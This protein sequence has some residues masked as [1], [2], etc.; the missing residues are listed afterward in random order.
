[1]ST[2]RLAEVN[3][4]SGMYFVTLRRLVAYK[5]SARTCINLGMIL[6]RCAAPLVGAGT[7]THAFL[8]STNASVLI[9]AR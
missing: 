3:S 5:Q 9:A 4:S 6:T 2:G 7:E 1:M 8:L